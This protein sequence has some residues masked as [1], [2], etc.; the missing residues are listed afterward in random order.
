MNRVPI[1]F[2]L[3]AIAL[4]VTSARGENFGADMTPLGSRERISSRVLLPHSG[5]QDGVLYCSFLAFMQV[6]EDKPQE[7][8]DFFKAYGGRHPSA[9]AFGSAGAD[10]K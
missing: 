2:Q 5:G 9:S 10:W 3:R 6:F 4:S 8:P 1:Q 7:I